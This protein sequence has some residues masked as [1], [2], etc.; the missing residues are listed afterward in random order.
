MIIAPPN[1]PRSISRSKATEVHWDSSVLSSQ[2]SWGRLRVL[3]S[4]NLAD[5][6]KG[7]LKG[8]LEN[9][10]NQRYLMVFDSI[11]FWSPLPILRQLLVWRTA[12]TVTLMRSH[13]WDLHWM[14]GT[15]RKR[16]WQGWSGPT[17]APKQFRQVDGPWIDRA[18]LQAVLRALWSLPKEE[19]YG[20]FPWEKKHNPCFG[21]H[22]N[23]SLSSLERLFHPKCFWQHRVYCVYLSCGQHYAPC[24]KHPLMPLSAWT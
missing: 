14:M 3:R 9:H 20:P 4:G 5:V 23:A 8:N 11:C 21:F 2:I 7:G 18:S 19:H 17:Q 13:W 10:Q 12:S 6:A 24:R 16:R 22:E 1:Y 15:P